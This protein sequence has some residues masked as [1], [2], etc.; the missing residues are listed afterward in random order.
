[1]D[2]LP[3]GTADKA[4]AAILDTITKSCKLKEAGKAL[5]TSQEMAEI[6]TRSMRAIDMTD[7]VQLATAVKKGIDDNAVQ[8]FGGGSKPAAPKPAGAK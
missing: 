6:I 4:A 3:P 8:K 1:M 2:T 7:T 5:P